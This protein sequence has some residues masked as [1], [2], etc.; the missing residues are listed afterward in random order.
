MEDDE[1]TFYCEKCAILLASK[2]FEVKKL[3]NDFK[4]T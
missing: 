4:P 3:D 2:G 1:E